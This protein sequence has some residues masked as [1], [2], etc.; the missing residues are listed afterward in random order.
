MPNGNSIGAQVI[1]RGSYA[2]NNLTT[3]DPKTGKGNPGPEWTVGAA[4]V[5]VELDKKNIPTKL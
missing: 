2:F 5:E 1:G 4:A 3:L